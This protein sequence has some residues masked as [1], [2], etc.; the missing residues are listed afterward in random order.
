MPPSAVRFDLVEDRRASLS[1]FL[2]LLP[3]P[4]APFAFALAHFAEA[5]EVGAFPEN[6]APQILNRKGQLNSCRIARIV[7][8]PPEATLLDQPKCINGPATYPLALFDVGI[9]ALVLEPEI[10][11]L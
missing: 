2:Q 1:S 6:D 8:S 9:V 10:V 3:L 7:V 5:G 11:D 4:V